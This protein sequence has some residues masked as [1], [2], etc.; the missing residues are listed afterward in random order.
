MG[1]GSE[2]F[3][4]VPLKNRFEEAL[5]CRLFHT[6]GLLWIPLSPSIYIHHSSS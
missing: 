2:G 6:E 3:R 4:G 5:P 1:M